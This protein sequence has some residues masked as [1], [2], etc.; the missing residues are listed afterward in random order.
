MESKT[1][2]GIEESVKMKQCYAFPRITTRGYYDLNTGEIKKTQPYYLY[3]KSKFDKISRGKEVVI[4]VHGMRNSRWGAI[5]GARLLRNKL[6]KLGYKYPIIAFSYDADVRG[7]HLEKNYHKVLNTAGRIAYDN[8]SYNLSRFIQDLRITNPSI[9][10]H[11]VGH[12]LGCDVISK[13]V[14]PLG[15]T[16]HLFG[17]PVETKDVYKLCSFTTKLVN[18][19]NPRD[20]VIRE[21]V[22]KGV[23]KRPSCLYKVEDKLNDVSTKN[24]YAKDHRFASY[25]EKLRK[26]P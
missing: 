7:A 17:S 1:E 12:S 26:F 22:E 15:G 25:V 19:Y 18:Y 23:I 21:G 6:R 9:K 20:E 3:P 24:C 14:L 2:A 11:L 13:I 8:G 5:H 10:I 16:I 4:F